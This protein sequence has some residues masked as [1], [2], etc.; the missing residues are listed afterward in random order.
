V[1]EIPVGESE[2]EERGG[3]MVDVQ[4]GGSAVEVCN[5]EEG[6]PWTTGGTLPSEQTE[7]GA[8]GGAVGSAGIFHA[9]ISFTI[10]L[11]G[12]IAESDVHVIDESGTPPAP[13]ANCPGTV[14]RPEAAPG[15]LCV[16]V[17][18][19]GLVENIEVADPAGEVENS[20]SVS[21]ALVALEGPSGKWAF[22]TWAVTAP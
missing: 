18:Y 8:W 22:G 20:A 15:Q 3:A 10:P 2:C 12:P 13:N 7:T 21:G 16:Y 1:D 5:G 11:E 19:K 14:K 6:S 9:P 4:G 17:V